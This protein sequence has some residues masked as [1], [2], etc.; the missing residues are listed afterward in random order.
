LLAL[1]GKMEILFQH[2]FL[3]NMLAVLQIFSVFCFTPSPVVAV[4]SNNAGVINFA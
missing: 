3:L 4:M 1:A 2:S